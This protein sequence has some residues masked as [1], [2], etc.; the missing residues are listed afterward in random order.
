M[1]SSTHTY[2]DLVPN[3]KNYKQ[4]ALSNVLQTLVINKVSDKLHWNT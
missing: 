4:A 2:L 1:R 3:N